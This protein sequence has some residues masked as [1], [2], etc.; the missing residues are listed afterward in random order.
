MD[1]SRCR[2]QPCCSQWTARGGYVEVRRRGD[3]IWAWV[4]GLVVGRGWDGRVPGHE[5]RG[6][7]SGEF[8][9]DGIRGQ[10]SMHGSGGIVLHGHI[11][12]SLGVVGTAA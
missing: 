3:G 10:L 8:G 2:R 12:T 1:E 11:G 6:V 5:C 9:E 7:M 4:G